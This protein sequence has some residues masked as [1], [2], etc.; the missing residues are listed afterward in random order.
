VVLHGSRHVCV[1]GWQERLGI[2]PQRRSP[3]PGL[4]TYQVDSE[5][6][7]EREL[8]LNRSS[9]NLPLFELILHLQVSWKMRPSRPRMSHNNS[10]IEDR[11]EP[12]AIYPGFAE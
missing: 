6:Q 5:L 8:I 9:V 11:E 4:E 3:H 1:G 7:D 12:C 2:L 10:Y